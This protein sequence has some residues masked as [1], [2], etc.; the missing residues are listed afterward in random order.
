[1]VCGVN[2]QWNC[3]LMAWSSMATAWIAL[4][5]EV[6]RTFA[7]CGARVT[8]AQCHCITL[9]LFSNSGKKPMLLPI[10]RQ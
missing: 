4:R 3:V 1:M 2:S 9:L 8:S 5:D 10:G 6:A 7:S